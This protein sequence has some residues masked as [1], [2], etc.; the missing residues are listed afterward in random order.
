MHVYLIYALASAIFDFRIS[1]YWHMDRALGWLWINGLTIGLG[2]WFWRKG[3]FPVAANKWLK[4][5]EARQ[6]ILM[7]L[8]GSLAWFMLP[9]VV[10]DAWDLISAQLSGW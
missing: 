1:R 6:V 4:G 7:W 5:R 3:R 2:I 9:E 10:D 8:G